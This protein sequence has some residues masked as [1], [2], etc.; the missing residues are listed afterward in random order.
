MK[1]AVWLFGILILGLTIFGY[2]SRAD[3]QPQERQGEQKAS[4]DSD[5]ERALKFLQGIQSGEKKKMY[6]AAN[7]T[8]DIVNDSREKLVHSKKYNLTEQQ[9][10][11][12]EH[13]LRISGQIDY[14]FKML[15][16]MFPKSSSIQILETAAKGSADGGRNTEHVVKITYLNKNEAVRDKTGKTVKEMAI[17]LRQVTRSINGRSIYQFSFSGKDFDKFADRDFEVLSYF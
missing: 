13:I 2:N 12:S 17:H 3:S 4:P 11:D 9:R 16:K 7:L 15:K 6:E 10:K 14:F 5:Q 8:P 1:K